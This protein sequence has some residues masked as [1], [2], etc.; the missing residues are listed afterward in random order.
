MP[1]SSQ[2]LNYLRTLASSHRTVHLSVLDLPMVKSYL[3][4]QSIS[5]D[6]LAIEMSWLYII[7]LAVTA[8]IF[9]DSYMQGKALS[10]LKQKAVVALPPGNAILLF[11][12]NDLA[13]AHM[14][15]TKTGNGKKLIQTMCEIQA[16]DMGRLQLPEVKLPTAGDI[17][18]KSEGFMRKTQSH[19]YG[20]S[21]LKGMGLNA[22]GKEGDDKVHPVRQPSVPPNVEALKCGD[23]SNFI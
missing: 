20:N 11:D 1:K 7:K 18:L 12:Y 15:Q 17:K 3:K 4:S 14:Y 19:K 8:D 23:V 5:A 9:Q 13:F 2:P 10:A 16:M 6:A 21:V 22:A